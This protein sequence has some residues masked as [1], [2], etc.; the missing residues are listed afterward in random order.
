MGC[1]P[2]H[3]PERLGQFRALRV[4]PATQRGQARGNQ[5]N[6]W[7]QHHQYH[8]VDQ[9][10]PEIVVC[11]QPAIHTGPCCVECQHHRSHAGLGEN[12]QPGDRAPAQGKR[13]KAE[14]QQ[15]WQQRDRAKRA[16]DRICPLDAQH[17]D[18]DLH[19]CQC[20]IVKS[21]APAAAQRHE[22]QA[23][24]ENKK[25]DPAGELLGV[26]PT[27]AGA[28]PHGQTAA[29]VHKRADQPLR[30]PDPAT[31]FFAE[32]CIHTAVQRDSRDAWTRPGCDI[33]RGVAF[34]PCNC[35]IDR[36]RRCR[37]QRRCSIRPRGR[38]STN[39]G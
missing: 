10:D 2:L 1:K 8:Q 38:T 23:Q 6:R 31:L 24:A 39:A 15:Q 22:H 5:R 16:G 4:Q 20:R 11:E 32:Q 9:I 26:H 28:N 25:S 13:A 36:R 30:G 33:G 27:G 7:Q 29:E 35:W 37:V 14:D 34:S 19:G 12:R 17:A 21:F 18:H 3:F